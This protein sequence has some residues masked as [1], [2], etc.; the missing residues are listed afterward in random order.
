MDYTERHWQA[1]LR[2]LLQRRGRRR[3]RIL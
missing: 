3:G 1:W 2:I